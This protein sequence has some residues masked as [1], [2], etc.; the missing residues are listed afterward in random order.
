MCDIRIEVVSQQ[1]IMVPAN[2]KD[3][4]S[5]HKETISLWASTIGHKTLLLNPQLVYYVP[6]IIMDILNA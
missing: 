4:P 3:L 6:F 1:T 5:A 2:W